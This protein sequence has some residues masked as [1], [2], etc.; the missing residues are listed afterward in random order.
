MNGDS[1]EEGEDDQ[2]KAE[3]EPLRKSILSTSPMKNSAWDE[4][5]SRIASGEKAVRFEDRHECRYYDIED[6]IAT[7]SLQVDAFMPSTGYY[8][9]PPL[10]DG[11]TA[12]GDQSLSLYSNI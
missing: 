7:S 9:D 6:H 10:E 2:D 1:E 11:T 5:R 4:G 8:A 3:R 12:I